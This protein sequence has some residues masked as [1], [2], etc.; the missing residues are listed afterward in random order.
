MA[1]DMTNKR[2]TKPVWLTI[3]FLTINLLDSYAFAN[4]RPRCKDVLV[5]PRRSVS[6]VD[7]RKQLGA[8][9]SQVAKF[10]LIS[11]KKTYH[12]GEMISLDL[13]LLNI[14]GSKIFFRK[15]SNFN[16]TLE[17][18]DEKG[19][20]VGI[21]SYTIDLEAVV[22]DSYVLVEPDSIIT[23]TYQ[24]IS[25]HKENDE[26]E[27]YIEAENSLYRE[28]RLNPDKERF[29]RGLFLN[30]GRGSLD[31]SNPGVYTITA[32]AAN[33]FVIVSPCEGNPKTVVGKI[34]SAPLEITIV[35]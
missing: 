35:P 1:R 31:I 32:T 13:A 29:N 3:V 28:G 23:W 9:Y 25:G 27:K 21:W 15:L 10:K 24:L 8:D 22:S 4:Q 33:D 30:V 19:S 14:S 6:R 12:L 26:L 7:E 20:T 5:T 11:R 17:A 16:I 2:K 18:R 34:I